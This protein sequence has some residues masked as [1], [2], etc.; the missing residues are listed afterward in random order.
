MIIKVEC[1]SKI[2]KKF[3]EVIFFGLMREGERSLKGGLKVRK[4]IFGSFFL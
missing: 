4:I 2:N 1:F 3:L